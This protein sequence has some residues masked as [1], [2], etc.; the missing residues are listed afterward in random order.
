MLR[1]VEE[2][3]GAWVYRGNQTVAEWLAG[4]T[5]G[6]A[7]REAAF[8]E[9]MMLWLANANGALAKLPWPAVAASPDGRNA[10]FTAFKKFQSSNGFGINAAICRFGW[11]WTVSWGSAP[12]AM[13]TGRRMPVLR[14]R[15]TSWIPVN[16]G[17]SLSV[18]SKS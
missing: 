5:D 11:F 9:M 10:R 18:T 3:P 17:I 13:M 4:S 6:V 2:F 8:E 12:D 7:H 16:P 1:F 14:I 15:S